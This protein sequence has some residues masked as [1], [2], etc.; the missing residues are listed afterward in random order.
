MKILIFGTGVIGSTIGWQ[1]QERNIITHYVRSDKISKFKSDG[2]NIHCTDLRLNTNNIIDA[3]YRPNFICSF[4]SITEYDACFISV[5]SNQLISILNEYKDVFKK[6]PVFIM[7]N[8]GLDDYPLLK[9]I[10]NDQVSFAYPFIMGGGRTDTTI[11]VTIFNSPINKMVVGN[12]SGNRKK[13]EDK[14]INEFA[15]SKLKP[16]YS[17]NIVA[18]LK[19]HYV[20]ATCVLASYITSGS[21]SQF[22][23][24]KE[25]SKSYKAMIECFKQFR[26]EK[27]HGCAIFPYNMY[28]L[29][30]VI[31]GIYSRMI[32]NTSAMEN[33]VVGHIT[34]SP[35]EM[36]IMFKSLV[37][38]CGDGLDKM[39]NFESYISP[40]N[41]YFDK[42]L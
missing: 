8:I 38:Y 42:K 36:N 25:I 33:M 17:K 16:A 12:F 24:V 15:C 29:P 19:L 5:K 27:I 30:S 31:L 37:D 10:F 40:V 9:D 14:V 3:V 26:R 21:Y 18:Y 23:T 34:S 35:D 1:L 7:Q 13:I 11:N 2:I 39:K 41:Q 6:I 4:D 22:I 32:Y 28:Y 20:W